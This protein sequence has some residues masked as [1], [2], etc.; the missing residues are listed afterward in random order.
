MH[1]VI[2]VFV[3]LSS[4]LQVLRVNAID[5]SFAEPF[6]SANPHQSPQLLLQSVFQSI[7]LEEK[8]VV[9][10]FFTI[11][12]S[13]PWIL[14]PTCI[15][16]RDR[17]EPFCLFTTHEISSHRGISIITTPSAAEFL[18]RNSLAFDPTFFSDIDQLQVQSPSITKQNVSGKGIGLFSKNAFER[19]DYVFSHTPLLLLHEGF[20][21]EVRTDVRQRLTKLAVQQLPRGSREVFWSQMGHF[22]GDQI[23]DRI[24]T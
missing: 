23:D 21:A 8:V 6:S 19:G 12:T 5:V 15:A 14:P 18:V 24:R 7:D 11:P 20:F 17:D 13:P 4:F 1:Y 16:E 9:E 2:H 3:I 10:D 22:G